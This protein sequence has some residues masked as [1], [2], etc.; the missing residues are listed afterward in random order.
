MKLE[1]VLRSGSSPRAKKAAAR[2]KLSNFSYF[3]FHTEDFYFEKK[4]GGEKTHLDR[5][6]HCHPIHFFQFTEMATKSESAISFA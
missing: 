5:H 4:K 6:R 2:S 3:F 1:L